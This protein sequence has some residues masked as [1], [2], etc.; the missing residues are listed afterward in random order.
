LILF[1]NAEDE[2][3]IRAIGS[4]LTKGRL[5]D[6]IAAIRQNFNGEAEY[7]GRLGKEPAI[8][9]K[10]EALPV[11]EIG[12]SG[13]I[14]YLFDNVLDFLVDYGCKVTLDGLSGQLKVSTILRDQ[15]G[16][17]VA[18]L[19]QN[20]W[21]V[22]PATWDRNYNDTALEVKDPT[23]HIVLQVKLLDDRIQLQGE[24]WTKG[25]GIRVLAKSAGGG[26]L[27]SAMGDVADRDRHPQIVPIFEYPS[28]L[29]L[30]ELRKP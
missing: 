16:N 5:D 23:G 24:W 22:S 21:K 6:L 12:N 1:L 20:E 28:K 10:G 9:I 14:F 26:A 29:H 27:M 19:I 3:K 18:E 4:Y 15:N 13:T 11:L 25:K 7:V 30:G 8:E 2:A 17:V